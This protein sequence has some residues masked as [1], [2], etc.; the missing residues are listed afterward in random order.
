M[1]YCLLY[2]CLLFLYFTSFHPISFISSEHFFHIYYVSLKH[3]ISSP[4]I[5]SHNMILYGFLLQMILYGLLVFFY[6]YFL[7]PLYIF[8]SFVGIGCLSLFVKLSFFFSL[9]L[10]STEDP[11]FHLY[12]SKLFPF[13]FFF[14]F[15]FVLSLY[16]SKLFFFFFFSNVHVSL[17]YWVII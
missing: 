1:K 15:F 4:K 10:L 6:K 14:L 3:K 13:F 2:F 12:R 5:S 8:F 17:L 9:C 16:R 11:P 7:A